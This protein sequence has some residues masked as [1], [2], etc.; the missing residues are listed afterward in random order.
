MWAA[1]IFEGDCGEAIV[2]LVLLREGQVPE[3]FGTRI[4]QHLPFLASLHVYAVDALSVGGIGEANS[5][6]PPVVL[7]LRYTFGELFIP[8]FR[9]DDG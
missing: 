6:L 1:F 2:P 5:Q 8:G 4:D 9:F 7:R 3:F